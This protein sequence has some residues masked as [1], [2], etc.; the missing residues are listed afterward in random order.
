MSDVL[1]GVLVL[2]FSVSCLLLLSVIRMFIFSKPPGRKMVIFLKPRND[3]CYFKTE[4]DLLKFRLHMLIIHFFICTI[5]LVSQF[6]RPNHD[7]HLLQNEW[8][9]ITYKNFSKIVRENMRF[10]FNKQWQHFLL[11]PIYLPQAQLIP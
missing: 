6:Q 8:I 10:K 4:S 9:V 11:G 7:I 3:K 1:L 5:A 2:A